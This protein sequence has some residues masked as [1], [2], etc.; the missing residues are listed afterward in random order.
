MCFVKLNNP[1]IYNYHRYMQSLYQNFRLNQPAGCNTLHV[2]R[3]QRESRKSYRVQQQKTVATDQTDFLKND[4]VFD[5]YVI[6]STYV[7]SNYL[8]TQVNTLVRF[9]VHAPITLY[10]NRENK[11]S[12]KMFG[13][14]PDDLNTESQS[15]I[16]PRA[17][18]GLFIFTGIPTPHVPVEHPQAT[19]RAQ[20]LGVLK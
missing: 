8:Q 14:N 17:S 20:I 19:T 5:M 13:P 7:Q 18:N 3:K 11:R 10:V 1:R 16:Y 15:I 2:R 12:G 6:Y 9:S 4:K